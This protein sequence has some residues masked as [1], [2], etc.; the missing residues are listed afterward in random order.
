MNI[1]RDWGWHSTAKEDARP[2]QRLLSTV[3]QRKN[4]KGHSVHGSSLINIIRDW[5][6]Q[7]STKERKRLE[8]KVNIVLPEPIQFQ[9]HVNSSAKL[10][11]TLQSTTHQSKINIDQY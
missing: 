3:Q 6:V 4:I 7:Y 9:V 8:Y 1:I 2:H 11:D 5:G 10:H